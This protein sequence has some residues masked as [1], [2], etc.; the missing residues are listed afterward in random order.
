[1]PK[2]LLQG[3]TKHKNICAKITKRDKIPKIIKFKVK[4]K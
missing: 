2:I 1:M 4:G 3:D